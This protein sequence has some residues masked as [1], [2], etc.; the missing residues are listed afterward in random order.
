MGVLTKRQK[1]GFTLAETLI[2]LAIIGIVAAMTVPNLMSN[3]RK[4]NLETTLAATYSILSSAIKTAQA[5]TG[6]SMEELLESCYVSNEAGGN[7]ATRS[8]CFVNTV[9]KP[10]VKYSKACDYNVSFVNCEIMQKFNKNVKSYK[11]LTGE[12]ET[13]YGGLKYFSY[14]RI[15]LNNGVPISV[16]WHSNNPAPIIYVDVNGAAGPN[17]SGADYFLF[18][19]M[20]ENP[21]KKQTHIGANYVATDGL[22]CYDGNAL[23]D[24]KKDKWCSLS[25][26][27]NG[28]GCACLIQ[29]NGWRFPDNYPIKKF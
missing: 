24:N 29:A 25:S 9:L 20:E 26:D 11:N 5:E 4:H 7:D 23:S 2:T 16:Y 18:S 3:Y 19:L 6:S 27:K 12:P 1:H 10:Y 13:S 22:R 8:D 17:Q 21:I 28:V 15:Q 14:S